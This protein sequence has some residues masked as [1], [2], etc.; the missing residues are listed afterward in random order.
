MLATQS[1]ETCMVCI[2]EIQ[3]WAD[4]RNWNSTRSKIL[5]YI[6]MQIRKVKMSFMATIQ[7][8]KWLEGRMSFQVDTLFECQ[9]L[10]FR[11]K[12][13]KKIPPRLRKPGQFIDLTMKDISG[14]STGMPYN[15]TGFTQ[16][17][18]LGPCDTFWDCYK[19]AD[20]QDISEAWTKFEMRGRKVI[21]DAS[22]EAGDAS[23]IDNY[24]YE[25][26]HPSAIGTLRDILTNYRGAGRDDVDAK[27]LKTVCDQAGLKLSPTQIGQHLVKMGV[28]KRKT[29]SRGTFYDIRSIY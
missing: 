18:T 4:R 19:T 8:I 29:K 22:E 24:M 20:T 15:K 21:L 28:P 14:A 17:R 23:M 13:N 27:E 2:D 7:D 1:Y 11:N 12:H 16:K 6:Q 3:F 25:N 9:D 26:R 10:Y 5:S